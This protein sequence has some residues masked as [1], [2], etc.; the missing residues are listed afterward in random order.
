MYKGNLN[1]C[2][3][4]SGGRRVANSIDQEKDAGFPLFFCEASDDL[5]RYKDIQLKVQ[6]IADHFPVDTYPK[7]L[8]VCSGLGHFAG[9]LQSRGYTVT[10]VELS[11]EQVNKARQLHGGV[12]FLVGDMGEVPQEEFDM[13][14]NTYSSFGYRPTVAEDQ[15]V[16]GSWYA[17]MRHEG[18]LIMEL[19]DLERAKESFNYPNSVI[20]RDNG[21]I[22]EELRCDWQ[23]QML[24]VCYKKGEQRY[25]G[26][27]RLYSQ[28]QLSDMLKAAGFRSIKLAGDFNGSQ[29]KPT[30]RLV[31]T[32][33]K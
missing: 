18:V 21:I 14:L 22:K 29:K 27:T 7:V 33:L 25:N 11:A 3:V 1:A 17:A 8:D 15:K 10:G 23:N 6:R 4:K 2:D 32:C 30:D 13:V 16:L 5:G 31:I 9:E 26:F 28:E 12:R 20:V 24:Y 19:T